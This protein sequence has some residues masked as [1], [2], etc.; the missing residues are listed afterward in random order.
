MDNCRSN[1]YEIRYFF[2]HQTKS[3]ELFY[4]GGCRS[5]S[6]NIFENYRDCQELCTTASRNTTSRFSKVRITYFV[7]EIVIYDKRGFF[8]LW[9]LFRKF[10]SSLKI[11]N[12]R[13]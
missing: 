6:K 11:N 12:F 4:Y 2:N 9:K 3:C 7:A 13:F 1:K 10:Y 5:K 8:S